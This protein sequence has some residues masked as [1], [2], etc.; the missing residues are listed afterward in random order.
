MSVTFD[1]GRVEVSHVRLETVH[2]QEAL[3]LASTSAVVGLDRDTREMVTTR[4]EG[5]VCEGWSDIGDLV[6]TDMHAFAGAVKLAFDHHLPLE[7]S[8]DQ[9]WI[10]LAQGAAHH[11]A[12]HA[13]TLRSRFVVHAGRETLRV[14]RDDFVKGADDNPWPEMVAAF[15]ELLGEHIGK[16]RDLFV[17][18]F[19]TT[20]ALE[21][22]VSQ[23]V[24]MGAVEKYFA[25]QF[26]SLC[27]IPKVT[28]H[29]TPDDWRAVR[30]RARVFRELELG[31]WLDALE[32]ILDHFV[33]AAEGRP[34]RQHWRSIYK[35]NE[36]SGGPYVTGWLQVLFPYLSNPHQQRMVENTNLATWHEGMNAPFGGG[37]IMNGFPSGMSAVPFVWEYLSTRYPMELL[38]GF[39]GVRQTDAGAVTPQLAWGV[40]DRA[41]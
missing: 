28:L 25:Y 14:R 23:V 12:L 13:D 31:P 35:L 2:V 15:T 33:A 9:V 7:L 4:A 6:A 16:K 38:A 21:R 18:D 22:T 34:D 41:G 17:A 20:G 19:S 8:P 3:L 26:A 36:S 5:P 10:L 39:A 24:L 29:G 11:V 32:P 30:W 27:G 40:R 37:P 1:V